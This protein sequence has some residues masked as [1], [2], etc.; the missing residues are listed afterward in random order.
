MDRFDGFLYAFDLLRGK[1]D[2]FARLIERPPFHWAILL[3]DTHYCLLEIEKL[4]FV[5]FC[6]LFT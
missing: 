2:W 3:S 4:F 1:A 5:S 6:Y